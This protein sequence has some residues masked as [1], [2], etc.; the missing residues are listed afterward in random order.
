MLAITVAGEGGESLVLIGDLVG[1][2]VVFK[3]PLNNKDKYKGAIDE[4]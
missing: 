3:I 1:R 2:N 4:T